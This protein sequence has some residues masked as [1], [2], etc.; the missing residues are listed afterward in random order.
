MDYI[1]YVFVASNTNFMQYQRE[2]GG[3][4]VLLIMS[5]IYYI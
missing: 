5:V 1:S 4:K 2:Y 3:I